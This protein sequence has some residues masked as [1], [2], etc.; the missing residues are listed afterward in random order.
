MRNICVID[1]KLLRKNAESIRKKLPEGVKFNAVV[2]A[3]G[4][5]HGAEKIASS[6]YDIVDGFSVSIVEEGINLR[7]AG[8]D[9][10]IIA[11]IPPREEDVVRALQYNVS[12]SCDSSLL[13][14]KINEYAKREGRLAFIHI[15]YD[16]GMN[17]LGVKNL[18]DLEKIL[19]LSKRLKW[20]K[21]VGF[22]SHYHDTFD[23]KALNKS[24]NKFLLA[25]PLVKRYNNN[26]TCHISASGGFLRGKFFDMVRIGIL[27]Y[28]YKPFKSTK[29]SVKPI[30]KIYVPILSKF[31]LKKGENALYGNRIASE[32]TQLSLVRYGYADGEERRETEE[33]FNNRC[34]DV[35]AVRGRLRGKRYLLLDNA[36]R[37]AKKYRTIS[38]EILVKSAIR[39][40]KVYKN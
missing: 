18:K 28:G 16:S 17:R 2:K 21:I 31:T 26:V 30:M 32:E 27:L 11:L 19:K 29:I 5:G 38:Y 1:L 22:F 13:L 24:T 4:Y 34:M 37:V 39:A 23:K 25:I 14:K 35:T 6:I 33:I 15:K 20:V 3:D 40:E 12:L 7:N 10:E 9:K 36:D 8:I